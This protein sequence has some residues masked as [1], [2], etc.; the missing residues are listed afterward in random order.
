MR[1]C[2]GA[3]PCAPGNSAI[4]AFHD[5][6][7]YIDSILPRDGYTDANANTNCISATNGH[8]HSN[9]S[10]YPDF[11]GDVHTDANRD[12]SDSMHI[13]ARFPGSIGIAGE[14]QSR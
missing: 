1:T 10:R 5:A 2:D 6:N 12:R 4:G 9:C 3:D 7:R 14:S 11:F 13:G 8:I